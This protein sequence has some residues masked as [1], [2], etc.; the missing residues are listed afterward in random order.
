MWKACKA[1]QVLEPRGWR[2]TEGASWSLSVALYIRDVYGLAATKPFFVPPMTP[3]VPEHIPVTGPTGGS[4]LA[5]E[6]GQWF[7]ALVRSRASIHDGAGLLLEDLSPAFRY[8]VENQLPQASEAAERF[9]ASDGQDF[10]RR[11]KADGPILNKVVRAVEK[12]LGRKAAPF[13]LEI[14]ILPVA[15]TWLHQVA[16]GYVLMNRGIQSDAAAMHRLLGP[17]IRGLA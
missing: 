12:E 5:D 13:D 4:A 11:W 16:P 10:A 7:D 3:Q 17:V 14:R 8:A 15:G 9:R 6:W 1:G 2:G